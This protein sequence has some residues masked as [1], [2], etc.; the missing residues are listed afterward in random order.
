MNHFNKAIRVAG[1]QGGGGDKKMRI[2]VQCPKES[3]PLQ[4]LWLLP[5][6]VFAGGCYSNVGCAVEGTTP[7]MHNTKMCPQSTP[8]WHRA[9]SIQHHDSSEQCQIRNR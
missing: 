4:R 9:S 1:E 6:S 2:D 8:F 3:R 7:R 5:E